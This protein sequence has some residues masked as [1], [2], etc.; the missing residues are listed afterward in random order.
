[1]DQNIIEIAQRYAEKVKDTTEVPLNSDVR[2]VI[3]S[4]N[5]MI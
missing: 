4:S 3:T 2:Y 1:M 5:S